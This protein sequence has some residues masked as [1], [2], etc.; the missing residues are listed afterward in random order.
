MYAYEI[1]SNSNYFALQEDK[2]QTILTKFLA[3]I[4]NATIHGDILLVLLKDRLQGMPIIRSLIIAKEDI[5]N[6]LES[7]EYKY[8]Q[9]D[10][11]S[12]DDL[13][14][15]LNIKVEREYHNYIKVIK[16]NNIA[17]AKVLTLISLPSSLQVGYAYNLIMNT[18]TNIII[19]KIRRL[20][21][22]MALNTTLKL[23]GILKASN[24]IKLLDKANKAEA[25]RVALLKQETA[26]FKVTF[27][28]IIINDNLKQLKKDTKEFKKYNRAMLI[29]YEVLPFIQ[30]QLLHTQLAKQLFIELGSLS[31]LY[32]FISNN[33]LELEGIMLGINL[34]TKSP[35]IYDYRLRDNYNMVILATSGSG[36]SVTA[37]VIVNRL[38]DKY[39]DIALFII[40]PQGEYEPLSLLY[41][42]NII[43]LTDYKPLGLDPFLLFDKQIACNVIADILNA[44]EIIRKEIL[45]LG[46]DPSIIIKSVNDLYDYASNNAKQYLIDILKDVRFK[47]GIR[48]SNRVILSLKGSYASNKSME[49]LLITLA[50]AKVWNTIN[51]M[52]K[53]IPKILLLDEGWL[54][55]NINTASQFINLIA[56]VG[57][58]LNVI[59]IFITQR[60]EDIIVNEYGRALLDNSDTKILLRNNELASIKIR[61]ALQLSREEEE[62]LVTFNKGEALLLTKEHRLRVYIMPNK[63]ELMMF[64][65]TPTV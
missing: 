2:Q 9:L 5:A 39:K 49:S 38:L 26:L 50:L 20:D 12:I 33:M 29:R 1:I 64:S 13:L 41:N 10:I 30:L 21:H 14:S 52:P 34:I 24:R 44:P 22:Y 55:F 57:R 18:N 42:A 3:L 28:A 6:I 62:S 60:P 11:S 15:N 36:K 65:T 40:D 46:L 63:E 56:R 54:L 53:D 23:E 59:M 37:K 43:R 32:P 17:Y 16:D 35:I 25:L 19:I 61:D 58:K 45:S 8:K 4:N 31:F 48:L 7:I 47:E 51:N 27:N